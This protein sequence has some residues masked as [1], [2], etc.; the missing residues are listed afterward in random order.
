MYT[1]S[2]RLLF[3]LFFLSFELCASKSEAVSATPKK[4]P[5]YS[6][7]YM[8]LHKGEAVGSGI[9][10]LSYLD[11]DRARYHYK[12]KIKWLVFSDKRSETSTVLLQNDQVIPQHYVYHRKGTGKDKSYEWSYN[13]NEHSATNIKKNKQ[14]SLSATEGLQD[15][16]SYHLQHRLNLINNSTQKRF[17]YPVINKSGS[18]KNYDYQYDGHEELMLPYGLIKT[19]RLKREITEKKRVTYAWFAPELNY[20]LVK[21]YQVKS[22]AEQF[23][24]Q[25]I[26]VETK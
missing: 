11:N 16:L 7:N 25:L 17:V 9:R 15:K 22:G 10:T 20:L 5:P 21:L 24:A 2:S 26:S 12:T 19:I 8:L 18:I 1:F 4:I 14:I 6:A 23:E 3:I 13:L